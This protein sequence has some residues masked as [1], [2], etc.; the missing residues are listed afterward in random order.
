MS[1][2]RI[3]C[4]KISTRR[5]SDFS[6]WSK[7]A[8][9]SNFPV[10]QTRKPI[11]VLYRNAIPVKQEFL[12]YYHQKSSFTWV[13]LHQPEVRELE[14]VRSCNLL[15]LMQVWSCLLLQ[16]VLQELQSVTIGRRRICYVQTRGSSN[17]SWQYEESP[18]KGIK[19]R[20]NQVTKLH[21]KWSSAEVTIIF[22][23]AW[24]IIYC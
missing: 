8:R 10:F 16:A 23:F 5:P 9:A 12:K 7:T 3:I 13:I 20:E 18:V 17:C 2:I 6:F 24:H 11:M 14:Q 22:M 4:D 19:T 15:Q 21:T 1:N